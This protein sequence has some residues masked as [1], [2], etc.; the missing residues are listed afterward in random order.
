MGS[1]TA[2]GVWTYPWTLYDEGLDTACESLASRGIE[3]LA[4]AVHHHS[5]RVLQPRVSDALFGGNRGGCYFD[6]TPDRFAETPIKPVQN[7]ISGVEDPLADI[8]ETAREHGLRPV[9]WTVCLHNSRLGGAYPDYRIEDA[10]GHPH[11][12]AF[13][14]ANPAVRRYLAG[15]VADIA[16]RGV[17]SIELEKVRYP[18]VFHGHG[19]TFGHDERQV[20]TTNAEERLFSQCFCDAC[21]QA[22]RANAVDFE[23]AQTVVK[24]LIEQ[25][26]T[27]PH[28]HPLALSDLVHEKPVLRD[29]FR[30]RIAVIDAVFEE[31]AAAAGDT[32]L[33]TYVRRVDPDWSAGVTL[34][35]I[36]RH[37]DRLRALCYVS[38]P[39]EAR[40][41]LRTIQRH[42][43]LPVDVGISIDPT[44]VPNAAALDALVTAIRAETD[45]QLQVY[46]HAMMT[47]EQ[48]AWVA[49]TGK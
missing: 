14:P 37:A 41:Q 21:R 35:T 40:E 44:L 23:H 9:A 2:T 5:A 43:D 29:L 26:F 20:L 39:D 12:H 22:A 33:S 18:S 13:C 1:N 7:E 48:L 47:D 19:R 36:E 17:D 25:S 24:K 4:V 3:T 31:I 8:V 10:F 6:P 30:F 42:T 49:A 34:S 15:V 46:N 32:D 11:D 28:S 45:G 38:D 27:D 16:A